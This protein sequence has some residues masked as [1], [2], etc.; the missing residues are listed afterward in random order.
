MGLGMASFGS[1]DKGGSSKGS[2]FKDRLAEMAAGPDRVYKT[3]QAKLT[4]ALQAFRDVVFEK[5]INQIDLATA[6]K[7]SRNEIRRE[8]EAFIFNFSDEQNTR[9]ALSEQHQV[10]E[11]IVNDMVGLGPLEILIHDDSVSDILVNAPD[12]IYV[13]RGGQLYA[14]DVSFRNERHVVQVA[15]RIANSI[16]RRIDEASP[17]VDARLKDGSRVNVIFPPLALDGASISIRKFSKK[18]ISLGD[19]VEIKS[20]SAPIRDFLSIAARCRLNILISGG[21]GAGKT[22]LLN[23]MSQLIDPHERI[24]TIEDSA[25]LKLQ[26]P[27]IVRLESRPPNLEGKG[28]ITIRDLLK[29]SLRMRPDRIIVGECRGSEVFD[30]L[31]AMNTGHDGSMSTVH[32]NNSQEAFTRLENM[33]L[34][35]GHEFP[36]MVARHYIADAIDLIVHVSRMRDGRRR[37]TQV[38]EILGVKDGRIDSQDIF[39]FEYENMDAK[40]TIHGTYR[41]LVQTPKVGKKAKLYGLEEAMQ[42]ILKDAEA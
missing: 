29:N 15:Q 31:Q 42:E 16:G 26:Q 7:M 14:T 11:D 36:P 9:I 18:N 28:E 12:K 1:K 39:N 10:A 35:T 8:V 19:M 4:K 40:G 38:T 5:L 33:L 25:E 30:M 32:A 41:C 17:M 21:T 20:L 37:I 34:M 6:A 3:S 23:A 2:A 22:T 24:V 13:E 27:H